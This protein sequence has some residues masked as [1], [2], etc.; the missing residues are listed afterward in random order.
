MQG[1]VCALVNTK[2]E[3]DNQHKERLYPM[4]YI[5]KIM[6]VKRFVTHVLLN[7]FLKKVKV[8]SLHNI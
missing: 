2:A 5:K 1:T 8:K 3:Y 6:E 7:N 4:I